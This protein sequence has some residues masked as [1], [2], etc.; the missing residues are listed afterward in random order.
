MVA[1]GPGD[2]AQLNIMVSDGIWVV[3]GWYRGSLWVV[4][5]YISVQSGAAPLPPGKQLPLPSFGT[6]HVGA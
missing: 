4:S 6:G 3:A 2:G 5:G 1:F